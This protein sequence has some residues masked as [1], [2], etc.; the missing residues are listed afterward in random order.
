MLTSIQPS[1]PVLTHC[2]QPDP[3]SLLLSIALLVLQAKGSECMGASWTI[4]APLSFT[5]QLARF[6]WHCC[7]GNIRLP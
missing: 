3:G 7:L 4:A 2:K 5:G 1:C 6:S